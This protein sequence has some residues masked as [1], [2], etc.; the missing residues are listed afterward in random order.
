MADIEPFSSV[1]GELKI[2]MKARWPMHGQAFAPAWHVCKDVC[3]EA[4]RWKVAT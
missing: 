1:F 2:S 3:K 4:S